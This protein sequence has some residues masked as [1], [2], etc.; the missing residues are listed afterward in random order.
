MDPKRA[1][2]MKAVG[3]ARLFEKYGGPQTEMVAPQPVVCEPRV[4]KRSFWNPKQVREMG[5]SELRA[6][7][8]RLE[9]TDNIISSIG[10]AAIFADAIAWTGRIAYEAVVNGLEAV[11]GKGF[12]MFDKAALAGAGTVILVLLLSR[13]NLADGKGECYKELLK[14]ADAKKPE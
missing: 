10:I 4:K 7:A 8:S 12:D 3:M 14:R 1:E 13:V 2:R 5:D 11:R 9:R 6:R